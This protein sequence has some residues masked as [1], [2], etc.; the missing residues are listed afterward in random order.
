MNLSKVKHE[1]GPRG[2]S[3]ALEAGEYR[4]A[5]TGTGNEYRAFYTGS[6]E[7]AVAVGCAMAAGERAGE[8]WV[9]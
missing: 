9:M 2:V 6:F 8:H 4:V 5:R 3:L 1:L 7:K